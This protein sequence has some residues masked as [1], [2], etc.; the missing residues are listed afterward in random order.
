M[1]LHRKRRSWPTLLPAN[2]RPAAPL[3]EEG[4]CHGFSFGWATCS[5]VLSGQTATVGAGIPLIHTGKQ[6]ITLV[7]SDHGPSARIFK[8]LSVTMVAISMMTFSNQTGHFQVD[9]LNSVG[10]ACGGSSAKADSLTGR[11]RKLL[12][13]AMRR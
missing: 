2:R 1:Y 13:S 6:R 11:R 12:R 7:H 9:P 10:S 8:S 3:F 5:H 4:G